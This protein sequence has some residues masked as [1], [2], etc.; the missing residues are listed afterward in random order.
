MNIDFNTSM[1]L[2]HSVMLFAKDD[3]AKD[4]SCIPWGQPQMCGPDYKQP[5]FSEANAEA[6]K[7]QAETFPFLRAMDAAAKLGTT[8]KYGDKTYDFSGKQDDGTFKPIGDIQIGEAF[9]RAAAKIAPELTQNQLDLANKFGTKFAQQRRNELE[10][11]DPRK[12]DLYEQFLSDV[13]GDAAAPDTRIDSPT[14]ERVGM[15][16][17]QKDTGASQLIRSELE[18]QIQQGLSQV[19]TLDP[20]MERRVQQA[21][22]ARGSSIGNVLGN[23][24]A[25]RESLA[26]QDALGNANSQRWNAAMGLLQSG[27]STSDTANRN[28][29]EAFQN[30]LAATGQRNTAAQQSFAG[31]MASQQQMLTGR[32][33]NIANVQ[34]ALGLQPVSSQAAQLGGLQ[35]GASPFITPQYTQ[36]MQMSRPGEL[37]SMGSNFALTNAKNQYEADQA[38]SFMN[39]FKGYAGAIGNLGSSY[40]GFGLGGGGCFVARECIPDQWEAF[41]FW[42]ELVG[43]KWFKSFY[44]SNAEKFAKWLKDKPKVKKLVAN[45]MITRI[46]SVIPKN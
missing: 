35:Q 22:R 1:V 32:Q 26:I 23:P 4:Y 39:Q 2:A 18:R 14:Y 44:D 8:V 33:Q 36:G 46:N 37:M 20:S 28:A 7:A 16:G 15:P 45:W 30:I 10:A 27:Q 6:V 31:Q 5:N 38:N 11:L 41:Y 19:G 13:K 40:A 43:P 17:S 34:S 21:A 12:F 3:W 42:K 25:L 9:A 29:Q 24:S